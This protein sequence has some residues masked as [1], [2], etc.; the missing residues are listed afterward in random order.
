MSDGNFITAETQGVVRV[1]TID[2]PP[3]NAWSIG[4]PRGTSEALAEAN[5]DDAI[6]AIILAG[7]TRGIF[8][9]ADIRIQGKPWPEDEPNLRDLIVDITQSK[10][11]VIALLRA[12]ALGGG[13]EIA[14]ACHYRVSTADCKMGQTEVNLGIPPGAGGTQLLPRLVG[15]EE[16]ANMIVTGRPVRGDHAAT[17]GLIDGLVGDD[18]I[19]LYELRRADHV[20]MKNDG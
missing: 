11:P 12:H 10:K 17:T 15:L 8:G 3:V 2:N 13:L 4:V 1:I 16:A 6:R 7:G 9:G 19:F 5:A 18:F 20:G 14:L